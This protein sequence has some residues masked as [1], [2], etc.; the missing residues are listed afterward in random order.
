[1]SSRIGTWPAPYTAIEDVKTNLF[2]RPITDRVDARL[3]IRP[4]VV[5]ANEVREA[6][7]RIG[8][9]VIDVIELL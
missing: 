7:G 5:P 6:L 2:T 3:Q 4:V 9:E 1:M 8:G